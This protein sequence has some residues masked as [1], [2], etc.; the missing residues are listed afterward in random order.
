MNAGLRRRMRAHGGEHGFDEGNGVL[1]GQCRSTTTN[2]NI[3][4]VNFTPAKGIPQ[5]RLCSGFLLLLLRFMYLDTSPRRIH[6]LGKIDSFTINGTTQITR[7]YSDQDKT[8]S[9]DFR[10]P[11]KDAGVPNRDLRRVC[12]AMLGVAVG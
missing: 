6:S 1:Q 11:N 7:R 4:P 9:G 10:D 5:G 3:P 2:K 12:Q 8:D